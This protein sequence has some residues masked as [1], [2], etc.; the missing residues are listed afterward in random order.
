MVD[1]LRVGKEETREKL[2]VAG[3]WLA[4]QYCLSFFFIFVTIFYVLHLHL[5]Q[6]HANVCLEAL[7]LRHISD[8]FSSLLHKFIKV[9]ERF[10]ESRSFH[11]LTKLFVDI[12]WI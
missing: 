9:E 12:A 8:L 6:H 4:P 1:A 7:K 11:A 10:T 2:E 3:N 5:Q